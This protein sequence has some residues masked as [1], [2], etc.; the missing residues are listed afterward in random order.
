MIPFEATDWITI[1]PVMRNGEKGVVTSRTKQ[2]DNFRVRLVEYS[3]GYKADHWC[4]IGHIVY[5]IDGEFTS[6]L[7]DGTEHVISKG[8][9]YQTSDDPHN[10]HRSV[11]ENGCTLFIVDG[12]FLEIE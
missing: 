2:Y 6:L 12:S 9:S 8:M 1:P 10:P 7:K 11:S 4:S 5:C 3:P